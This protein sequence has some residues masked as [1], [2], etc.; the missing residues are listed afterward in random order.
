VEET[1][2]GN[3]APIGKVSSTTPK[4]GK[5]P[6]FEERTHSQAEAILGVT[7]LLVVQHTTPVKR[8]TANDLVA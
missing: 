3:P 7:R 8:E 1:G 6:L 2:G 5:S 4:L